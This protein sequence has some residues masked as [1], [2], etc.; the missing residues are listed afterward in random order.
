ML[1][2][3]MAGL[4]GYLA[5]KA[6][7]RSRM[8]RYDHRQNNSGSSPR[9]PLRLEDEERLERLREEVRRYEQDLRELADA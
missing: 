1:V 7:R 9:E 6:R 4:L 8:T 3:T 2:L 5:D